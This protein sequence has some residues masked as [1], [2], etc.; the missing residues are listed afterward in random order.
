MLTVN[1]N[2]S[3]KKLL[4][5]ELLISLATAFFFS[6]F[7]YF[8]YFDI[9]N[10]LV[11][12]LFALTALT[13]LLKISKR[14]ILFSGFFIGVSWFYWIGFSFEYQG[15]GYLTPFIPFVF[16]VI[17]MLF[18]APLTLTSNI[19]IRATLLFLLSFIEPMNF[20]WMQIELL[21]VQSYIGVQKYHLALV[22]LTLVLTFNIK[23]YYKF[24]A[25][26]PL[27]LALFPIHVTP[28]KEP[29]LKIKLVQ[30][31][32]A[33]KD[34]WRYNYLNTTFQIIFNEIQ[35]AID[36]DYDVILL[37]ES[38]FPIYMNKNPF[39][40][41]MLQELSYKITIVAGSLYKENK[42]HFNVTYMF[43][44]GSY[45]IAKKVVLVPFGEYIPLPKFAQD[46]INN[47]F[48]GGTSDFSQASQPTDFFI[49][50]VKF[51]NAICYE[52]TTQKIYE[53]DVKYVLAIS[54]NGWFVPSIEP[55]LQNLLLHYYAKKNNVIIYHSANM[56]G[57][58]VIYPLF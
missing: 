54:N 13:L 50:G 30:T 56:A 6:S 18:F 51:R 42:E 1:S 24:I 5:K 23:K 31:Q 45:K 8:E 35:Q 33:Q 37:P 12:T 57:S 3:R 38:V 36:K 29:Q 16:G 32:I 9:S 19:Y 27:L 49:D 55:T 43:K 41:K 47:T 46:F 40:I 53:G 10:K 2:L 34:K 15:V 4:L 22:L 28:I 44:N 7:I 17:Y 14:A 25:I 20:N 48:F 21:F 11:N 26:L 39:I 58:G 52:A